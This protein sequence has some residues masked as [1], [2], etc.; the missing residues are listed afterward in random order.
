MSITLATF[1][2]FMHYFKN[3]ELTKLYPISEKAVR[4]WI[5]GAAKGKNDLQLITHGDR[6]YIANTA[7]NQKKIE[8]LIARGKKYKNSRGF[9]QINPTDE[10]YKLYNQEQIFDIISNIEVHREIP[11]KYTYFDGGATVWNKYSERLEEEQNQNALRSTIEL[12]KA[13]RANIDRHIG[14]A[15][16]VNVI[17]LG[18][19][20]GRPVKELIDHLVDRGV[21]NRYIGIDISKEMLSIVKQNI[22]SWFGN[23]VHF[24]SY[25]RDFEHDRFKDLLIDDQ[26]SGEETVN[27]ALLLGG[28]LSNSRTPG[29]LLRTVNNSLAV[30]DLFI[31]TMRTD[32]PEMR[33]YFDYNIKGEVLPLNPQ[34]SLILKTL[35]IEENLYDVENH[36]NERTFMRTTGIRLKVAITIKFM[37]GNSARSVEL[38]KGDG[39]LLWRARH[40]MPLDIIKLYNDNGFGLLDASLT[41]NHGYFLSISDVR[42][43]KQ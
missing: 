8:V 19:G 28:T 9:K 29:D 43:G 23:K 40:L 20:N 1:L 34:M 38:N 33:R 27:I 13:N 42:G 14:S 2:Y 32:T 15:K 36:F 35:G 24:E 3:T 30:N 21:L 11:F 16:R 5:D 4:N 22:T 41:S 37:F 18:V 26:L 6:Q 10:F 17:D 39:I 12:L 25:A 31:Q 7:P